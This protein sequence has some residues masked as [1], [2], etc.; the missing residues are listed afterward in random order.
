MI[1]QLAG[2]YGV[3]V[4]IH[5]H[6]KPSRYWDPEYVHEL[7]RNLKNIGFTADVGHWEVQRSI[8]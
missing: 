7:T 2:E 1:D 3:R 4:G 6:P 5:D 8:P